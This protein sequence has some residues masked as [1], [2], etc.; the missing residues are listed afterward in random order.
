MSLPTQTR[1]SSK[2]GIVLM[3]LAVLMFSLND[4]LG[5]YLVASYSVGQLLLIRSTAGLLFLTPFVLRAGWRSLFDI[6]QPKLM[7]ARVCLTTIEISSF[8][9]A[10]GYMPLADAMT[11]WMAAPIYVAALS[12]LLLGERVG[13]RR[14]TAILIGFA[15]V[16]IA[17]RPS[18]ETL[19]LP[20]LVALIGSVSFGFMM[21]TGRAL[22]QSSDLAMVFWPIFGVALIGLVA[23]PWAKAM[24]TPIDFVLLALLGIVALSAHFL[25]N[26]SL[27]LADA[28]TVTPYQY[29]LLVWAMIFGWLIFN[30]TPRI[31]TIIG[32]VVIVLSGLFIFLREQQLG[33]KRNTVTEVV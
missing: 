21:I 13:W 12:P 28:A 25:T 20:A 22:R 11:F 8:Y 3:L 18:S 5:K 1:D 7:V 14:W 10:V 30:E 6:S 33:I 16:I 27:M 4:V 17:L 15:G 2:L 32:A 29:T 26:R 24:P 19:T 23:L 9:Y 31:T